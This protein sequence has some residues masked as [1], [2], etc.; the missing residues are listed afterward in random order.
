M[1]H[2]YIFKGIV[3]SA[4]LVLGWIYLNKVFASEHHFVNTTGSFEHLSKKTNIDVLFLGSSHI[5]TAVNPYVIDTSCKTVSFNLGTDGMRLQFT[6]LV[7]EEALQNTNPKLVVVEIF[8]GSVSTIETDVS[9]GFQLRALDFISNYRISKWERV[10]ENFNAKEQPGVYSTLIRNHNNWNQVENYVDLDRKFPINQNKNLYHSGYFGGRVYLGEQDL[11]TFADFRTVSREVNSSF[12]FLKPIYLEELDRLVAMSK[13][14]GFELLVLTAPDLRASVR[15]NYLFEQ[16]ESYSAKNNLNYLNLSSKAMMDELDIKLTDFKDPSHLNLE[17]G[18]KVS[19]FLSSYI[20]ANYTLPDRS[21][22]PAY[23]SNNKVYQDKFFGVE[24]YKNTKSFALTDSLFIEEIRIL[25]PY[26][27]YKV[28]VK[29]NDLGLNS[30]RY[31]LG[32]HLY[33]K[34]G[35]ELELSEK[36]RTNNRK[37]DGGTG[38]IYDTSQPL[39]ITLYSSIDSIGQFSFFLYDKAGY[40]GRIGKALVIKQDE[41]FEM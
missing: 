16:L 22:E 28:F 18:Q 27:N 12:N 33:P 13:S 6:S 30:D 5:Y 7:L 40:K 25:R 20:N 14:H 2:K 1:W 32:A 21:L 19:D 11:N 10:R 3:F 34:K 29:F 38:L 26:K 4:F 39:E 9:K 41:L 8:R 35:F 36:S 23:I 24:I 15:N 37:F 17:G 31:Q